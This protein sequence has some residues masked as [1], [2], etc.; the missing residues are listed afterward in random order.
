MF[1][2]G[3]AGDQRGFG[4][5]SLCVQSAL[6]LLYIQQLFAPIFYSHFLATSLAAQ[7]PE[8]REHKLPISIASLCSFYFF[9]IFTLEERALPSALGMIGIKSSC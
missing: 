6:S 3:R 7:V 4:I 1:A 9:I 2:A 8:H 5:T